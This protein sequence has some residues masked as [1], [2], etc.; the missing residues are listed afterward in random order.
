MRKILLLVVICM[1]VLL[2]G[3]LKDT[4]CQNKTIESEDAAMQSYAAANGISATRHSS[5]MYYQ[6]LSQGTGP[7][8][9]SSSVLLVKYTGKLT[10]GTVFDSRTT[11]PVSLTLPQVIAGWQIGLPLIQEGG[12]IKLIVPSSM[13]YGC[14]SVGSIPSNSI[15]YFEI[16]LVDVQ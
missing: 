16:E 1:A 7:A 8:P 2:S 12:V 4:T 6:I 13:G 10:N 3:C 11:S 5:G 14:A 9:T 15:L